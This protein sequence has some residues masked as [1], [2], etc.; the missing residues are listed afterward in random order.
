MNQATRKRGWLRLTD[1]KDVVEGQTVP[2]ESSSGFGAGEVITETTSN[3]S[4]H[5]KNL[6][7][8][9][10]SPESP[11]CSLC[12]WGSDTQQRRQSQ[13]IPRHSPR[14]LSKDRLLKKLNDF[15]RNQDFA[16]AGGPHQFDGEISSVVF[17]FLFF[18]GKLIV[19]ELNT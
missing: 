15:C 8:R 5:T 19:R 3:R 6:R 12:V 9:Y 2:R 14:V 10:S 18:N 1:A 16:C 17:Y 11:A 13:S 7:F 4:A